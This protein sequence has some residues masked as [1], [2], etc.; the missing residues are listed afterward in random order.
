MLPVPHCPYT[1]LSGLACSNLGTH[2][3][4][5]RG[6]GCRAGVGGAVWSYC[7]PWT[8]LSWLPPRSQQT[9]G[10]HGHGWHGAHRPGRRQEMACLPGRSICRK[11]VLV[12]GCC[13]GTPQTS[14]LPC[15]L[16]SP[17]SWVPP[18]PTPGNL[19]SAPKGTQCSLHSSPQCWRTWG[20]G[21]GGG[22]VK[23]VPEGA[24][25]TCSGVLK[26]GGVP[27][28]FTMELLMEQRAKSL[29]GLR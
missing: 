23:A 5:C 4:W 13:E 14:A 11:P 15:G 24:W 22:T 20:G 29:P 17:K 26:R 10:P 9:L 2:R 28:T 7:S 18:R 12:L 19:F 3:P 27:S 1:R 16:R 21:G 25:A 6:E 8:V